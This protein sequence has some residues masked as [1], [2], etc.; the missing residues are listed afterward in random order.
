MGHYPSHCQSK[1]FRRKPAS[2]RPV[3]DVVEAIKNTNP[4]QPRCVFQLVFRKLD[5]DER[6]ID[7]GSDIALAQT[8]ERW[9]GIEHLS[10]DTGTVP[11]LFWRFQIPQSAVRLTLDGVASRA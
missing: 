6:P 8:T 7:A 10:H 11:S 1:D 4:S 2:S 9:I 3:D 5:K